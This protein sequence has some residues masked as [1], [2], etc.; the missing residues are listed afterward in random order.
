MFNFNYIGIFL[1]DFCSPIGSNYILV[2]YYQVFLLSYPT[3][4]NNKPVMNQHWV[5]EGIRL[6]YQLISVQNTRP[7]SYDPNFDCAIYQIIGGGAACRP[8]NIQKLRS[9]SLKH[10]DT[11]IGTL[12]SETKWRAKVNRKVS[13][14]KTWTPNEC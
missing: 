9:F 4:N 11:V 2:S 1:S 13:K 10:P 6:E 14:T 12:R 7:S 3:N 5:L 8:H